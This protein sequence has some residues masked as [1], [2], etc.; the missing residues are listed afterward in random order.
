ML[1]T[2]KHVKIKFCGRIISRIMN[3]APETYLYE[4]HAKVIKLFRI[5][6]NPSVPEI[7]TIRAAM[8]IVM[9]LVNRVWGQLC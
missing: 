3:Q 9:L 2:R 6:S 8:S 1:G 4:M 7:S 5:A